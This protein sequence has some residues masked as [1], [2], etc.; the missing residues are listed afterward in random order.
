[1]DQI[2]RDI[3]QRVKRKVFDLSVLM[4]INVTGL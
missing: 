1:M 4:K 3:Y 2:F